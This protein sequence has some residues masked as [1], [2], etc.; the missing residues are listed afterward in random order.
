MPDA[1]YGV[2]YVDLMDHPERYENIT[3]TFKALMCHSKKFKGIDCPGRFAMVCCDKDKQFLALVCKGEGLDRF[4]PPRLGEAPRRRQ[5][6]RTAPPTRAP[7]GAVCQQNQRLPE[8][9]SGGR[10]VLMEKSA[11]F[12]IKNGAAPCTAAS[13]G[14]ATLRSARGIILTCML[15]EK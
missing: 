9:G 5:G 7:S 2:W 15:S 8:G 10:I 13:G 11:L 3:V 4:G 14:A 12:S 6:G 1:D